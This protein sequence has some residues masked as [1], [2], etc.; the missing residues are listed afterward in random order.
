MEG[1]YKY[2]NYTLDL[3]SNESCLDRIL[4]RKRK[5]VYFK[6]IQR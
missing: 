3:I 6:D 1:L 2:K 4:I 5:A